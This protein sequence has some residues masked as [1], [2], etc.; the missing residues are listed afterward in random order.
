MFRRDDEDDRTQASLGLARLDKIDWGHAELARLSD[1]ARLIYACYIDDCSAEAKQTLAAVDLVWQNRYAYRQRTATTP[2]RREALDEI[3]L[4]VEELLARG[5][6][7]LVDRSSILGG[8]IR[9][10]WEGPPS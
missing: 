7:L 10:P 2:E 3:C 9:R 8:W 5:L 6:L 4:A 1:A